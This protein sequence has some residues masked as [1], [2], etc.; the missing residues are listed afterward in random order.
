M[1]SKHHLRQFC[2]FNAL[3]SSKSVSQHVALDPNLTKSQAIKAFKKSLNS[4]INSQKWPSHSTTD[5]NVLDE[6]INKFCPPN[7]SL[8]TQMRKLEQLILQ[9]RVSD[10]DIY[11]SIQRASAANVVNVIKPV[12]IH[13][14]TNDNF[15]RSTFPRLEI[16]PGSEPIKGLGANLMNDTISKLPE[17]TSNTETQQKSSD[18]IT[19]EEITALKKFLE[20]AE[21]QEK[22]IK[23]FVL[24]QQRKYDWSL[25]K[26]MNKIPSS[27]S[28]L[29]ETAPRAK[30][31]RRK[32][33]LTFISSNLDRLAHSINSMESNK[34]LVYDVPQS[35]EIIEPKN[36]PTLLN[37]QYK[38]LFGVINTGK[39]APDLLLEL[40]DK[41]ENQ[42]W[43]LV[44]DI[45]DDNYKIVFRQ[46]PKQQQPKSLKSKVAITTIAVLG[47]LFILG[48]FV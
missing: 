39:Y 47:S 9:K 10:S 12:K 4:T 15:K 24:Q 25:D 14:Q 48:E 16:H 20:R 38:D 17:I 28:M 37:V 11:H 35:K 5:Q 3:R 2:C 23:S 18:N 19:D 40:V 43:K 36:A 27:G 45:I 8:K 29:F 31:L 6:L 32:S 33:P 7:K 30:V 22:E 46:I 42:G 44:G 41:Y 21:Q 26:E 1:S 13:S 34:I